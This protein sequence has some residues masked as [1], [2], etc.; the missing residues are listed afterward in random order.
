MKKTHLNALIRIELIIRLKL[1]GVLYSVP[2]QIEVM[3]VQMVCV[4]FAHAHFSSCKTNKPVF[5]GN[6]CSRN[7]FNGAAIIPNISS[8]LKTTTRPCGLV[9]YYQN[10]HVFLR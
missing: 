10:F 8:T 5:C 9:K 7:Y 2:I 4:F 1:Q 3:Y 6:K